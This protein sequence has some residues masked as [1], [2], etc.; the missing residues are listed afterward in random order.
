MKSLH[1][2]RSVLTFLSLGVASSTLFSACGSPKIKDN[3]KADAARNTT[4]PRAPDKINDSFAVKTS[5]VA[6]KDAR[7][8]PA[9]NVTSTVGVVGAGEPVAAGGAISVI[10]SRIVI[11]KPA[12]EKEF[13]LQ[14]SFASQNIVPMGNSLL[15]RVVHFKKRDGKLFLM[16]SS[17]GNLISRDFEQN[18]VLASF[19]ILEETETSISFDFNAGM[20]KLFLA[21]DWYASDYDGSSYSPKYESA[22]VNE[23]YLESATLDSENR[24]VIR[25]IA[26]LALSSEIPGVVSN[27]TFEVK[28]FL[29][30]YRPNPAFVPFNSPGFDRVGF[31]EANPIM[32]VAGNSIVRATKFAD[33][34]PIVFAISANTPARV[35]KAVEEGVL[36]WNQAFGETRIQTTI[37]PA[38][39]TA[40]NSEHNVIQWVDWKDAGSAYADAQI[41]PRTG[42]TLHAQVYMTSAFDVGSRDE[43]LSLLRQSGGSSATSRSMGTGP[44]AKSHSS[45]KNATSSIKSLQNHI[46]LRGFEARTPCA[47]DAHSILA[48]GLEKLTVDGADDALV[49]KFALDTI[50]HVMAHEVGHVLGLRH[51]FAGSLAVSYTVKERDATFARYLAAEG[52]TPEGVVTTSSVMD[53]LSSPELVM[54]GDLISRGNSVREYDRKAI[55]ILYRGENYSRAEMPAFCTDTQKDLTL[56]C[57]VWDTGSDFV[58][59]A[60]HDA[61]SELRLA[62]MRYLNKFVLAKTSDIGGTP[63]RVE[64]VPLETDLHAGFVAFFESKLVRA[65]SKGS[66]SLAVNRRFGAL[67]S[68]N[69]KEREQANIEHLAKAMEREGSVSFLK[70]LP[71]QNFV[72]DSVAKVEQLL[73]TTYSPGRTAARTFEFDAAEKEYILSRAKPYFEDMERRLVTERLYALAGGPNQEERLAEASGNAFVAPGPLVAA[74]TQDMLLEAIVHVAER[75]LLSSNGT[76]DEEVSLPAVVDPSTPVDANAQ[77]VASSGPTKKTLSLPVWTYSESDRALAAALFK[78]AL[79]TGRS[80]DS[81]WG[82]R[83]RLALRKKLLERSESALGSAPALVTLDDASEAAYKWIA[84]EKANLDALDP[85]VCL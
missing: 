49:E 37:A 67:D 45:R 41:D 25:Q 43:A 61:E 57:L 20:S 24:L 15:S 65:L 85:E 23:S 74:R 4:T 64:N 7:A 36:Y 21:T 68:L 70:T 17:E 29:S 11:K 75:I 78:G 5:V 46:A 50:R 22:K 42:E 71:S 6:K 28:Y 19:P 8:S 12:L 51:N 69:E 26:Q 54:N 53:Y 31:F 63:T 3:R 16:E 18:L 55:G 32:D 80:S 33:G 83:A 52:Q 40:A 9:S 62:P 44:F 34:K 14:G 60:Q 59:Y 2:H 58:A 38:G 84:A 30:P 13:L 81:R 73:A 35:R 79:C 1:R 82:V 48:Q 10:E 39:V 56:D 77:D 76:L 27:E 72:T 47:F 66:S